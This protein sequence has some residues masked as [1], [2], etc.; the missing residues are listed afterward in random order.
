MHY[1]CWQC[2]FWAGKA[3]GSW[4]TSEGLCKTCVASPTEIS[5]A[6]PQPQPQL[7]SSVVGSLPAEAHQARSVLAFVIATLLAML[8]TMLPSTARS[9]TS[10]PTATPSGNPNAGC[11]QQDDVTGGPYD[12]NC[13][14]APSQNG[15]GRDNTG[16]PGPPCAG[17]VG[18][19]DNQQPPGQMPGGSD[20]NA[21]YE[22]DSNNGIGQGNPA[23]TGCAPGS[24]PTATPTPTITPTPTPTPT[25]T[26]TPRV[27][28]T[29]TPTITPRVTPTPSAG[30]TPQ[31][32]GTPPLV[33]EP[34]NTSTPP[35]PAASPSAPG[36][37]DGGSR[38]PVIR[39]GVDEQPSRPGSTPDAVLGDRISRAPQAVAPQ[40]VAASVSPE[41]DRVA[42]GQLP[43]TG[44]PLVPFLLLG[45]AITLSGVALVAA[46]RE[47]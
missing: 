12:A 13:T 10:D 20:G 40:V 19:A 46:A 21:G 5:V 8:L 43:F 32:A 37:P 7:V 35:G 29:P 2:G 24:T 28:P 1:R 22:C 44:A 17:C 16:I 30:A 9:E 38:P 34:S 23:H 31:D 3:A 4:I 11:H 39:P 25:P 42:A 6:P 33:P 27:T 26:I 18:Q 36:I 45:M 14:G 47:G 41:S 15:N